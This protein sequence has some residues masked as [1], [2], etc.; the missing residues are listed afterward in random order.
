[1]DQENMIEIRNLSFTY[2]DGTK[3][4]DHLDFNLPA[5]KITALLGANGAGKSSLMMVLNGLLKPQK[6]DYRICLEKEYGQESEYEPSGR[7]ITYHR[8][9]LKILRQKVGVVFQEP[10][11]QLFSENVSAEITFGMRNLNKT[12]DE[13]EEGLHWVLKALDLLDLKDKP[14]HA[15]SYGQ[16]KRVCMAD[17]LVMKP[18]VMVLDEPTAGLDPYHHQKMIEM[19]FYLKEQGMTLLVSTHDVDSVWQFADQVVVLNAGK[20]VAEGKPEEVF[21][22][23][24]LLEQSGLRM[25]YMMQLL[26]HLKKPWREIWTKRPKTIRTIMEEI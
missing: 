16:K 25:P 1:M 2:E 21:E 8:Q 13:I 6:G 18:S 23:E 3:A 10:D 7:L 26:L 14:T 5:G 20:V 15:L 9:Q 12:K 4:L 24:K 11:T 19:L 17:I 22:D